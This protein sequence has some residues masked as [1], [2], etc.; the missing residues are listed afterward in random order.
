M[1]LFSKNPQKTKT[2]PTKTTQ[3][4]STVLVHPNRACMELENIVSCPRSTSQR[5]YIA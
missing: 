2:K 1:E 3:E 5:P 4:C